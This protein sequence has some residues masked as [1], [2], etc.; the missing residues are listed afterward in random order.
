MV[1]FTA[2]DKQYADAILDFIDP[3]STLISYR[4]YRDSCVETSCGFVK[5]LRVI[6]NRNLDEIVLVDNSVLSFAF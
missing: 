1:A 2:A 4:I 6:A 5:D 3:D